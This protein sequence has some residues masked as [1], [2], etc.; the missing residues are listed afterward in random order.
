MS[1]YYDEVTCLSILTLFACLQEAQGVPVQ[2]QLWVSEF[3]SFLLCFFFSQ[4]DSVVSEMI[5]IGCNSPIKF[6][7]LKFYFA[8]IYSRSLLV[9]VKYSI[10]NSWSVILLIHI[11]TPHG[12][13]CKTTVKNKTLVIPDDI[14]HGNVKVYLLL[15]W[16]FMYC[17]TGI[18]ACLQEAK[19]VGLQELLVS[20]LLAVPSVFVF[21][22]H[23]SVV[24]EIVA[25]LCSSRSCLS[26]PVLLCLTIFS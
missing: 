7:F 9:H 6:I 12:V 25:T 26:P 4:Y 2:E 24:Q 22:Q 5:A 21:S 3:L 11:V 16:R 14:G 10:R 8:G 17:L 18:V 13:V 20:K 1:C 19:G 15:R 23:L